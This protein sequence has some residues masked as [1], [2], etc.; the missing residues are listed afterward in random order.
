M[1]YKELLDE[2]FLAMEDAYAP[3]SKYKVGAWV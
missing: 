1:M 2:A 3:H